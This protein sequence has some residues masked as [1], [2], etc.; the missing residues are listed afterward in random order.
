[1]QPQISLRTVFCNIAITFLLVLHIFP[2]S[3]QSTTQDTQKYDQAIELAYGF[4]PVNSRNNDWNPFYWTFDDGVEMALVPQGC[5]Y[6][7]NEMQADAR[8]VHWYCIKKP[9][10][11][12]RTEV[13]IAMYSRC[14]DAGACTAPPDSPVSWLADH[15]VTRIT[16]SQAVDYCRWRGNTVSLPT[17]TQWEYAARGVSNWEYPWGNVWNE[18]AAIFSETSEGKA[19]SAGSLSQGASW[20]GALDLSGN[21]WEWVSSMFEP[22]PYSLNDGREGEGDNNTLRAARGG[23][24]SSTNINELTTSFR[25]SGFQIGE[26]RLIGFRCVRDI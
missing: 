1:M 16:W 24:L 23:S 15:P 6:M 3:G 20:V 21:V 19:A 8:P 12:D 5:F 18:N 4:D 17:E 25:G 9:F 26:N 10:W 13:T 7:G 11:I 22:Y 2:A 14:V